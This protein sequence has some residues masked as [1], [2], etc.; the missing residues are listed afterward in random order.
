V[1]RIALNHPGGA[2]GF[3]IDDRDGSAVAYITDNELSPPGTPASSL[4]QL[5]QFTRGVGLLIH[6]AQYTEAD[7]PQKRGWGH[8]LISDVL[9]LGRRA[10]ARTLA[11]FHHEPERDDAALDR[12][13]VAASTWLKDHGSATTVVVSRE[14]LTIDVTRD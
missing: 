6:D 4:E 9:E 2:Q 1:S 14:G 12:I 13:G 5:A 8:S 11:L 3:R 10:E 7:M